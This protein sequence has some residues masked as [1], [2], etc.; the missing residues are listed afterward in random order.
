MTRLT[1]SRLA[2]LA[3]LALAGL[4]APAAAQTVRMFDEAPSL[5]VLRAIMVP[6]SRGAASRRIV[7]PQAGLPDDARP[8]QQAAV[9]ADPVAAPAE[10]VPQ[11]APA[12]P[13]PVQMAMAAPRPP[14]AETAAP[15]APGIIGFR[16]NFALDSDT[17][18][19]AYRGFVE[20]IGELLRA[21][22]QV[23]LRIEGHTDALGSDAYNRDL[24]L[25]RAV[26]VAGYLVDHM[27]IDA[28]RL[29]VVGKGKTEP[30]LDDHLDPRNRRVQF[31]RVD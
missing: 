9:P 14:A 1:L 17:L 15:A 28:D 30:L 16:I 19:P 20:R 23:K 25:R 8:V 12:R 4:A 29:V 13:A 21:E 11:A 18:A 24:S 6:E 3:P 2:L 31:V 27:G 26:A 7:L 10:P 22:P 5:E